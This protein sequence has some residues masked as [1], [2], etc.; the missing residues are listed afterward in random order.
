LMTSGLFLCAGTLVPWPNLVSHE[1]APGR[2]PI[3]RLRG[4]CQPVS[5]YIANR[6]WRQWMPYPGFGS[7]PTF[8]GSR[9]A[10]RAFRPGFFR[11][12]SRKFSARLAKFRRDTRSRAYPSGPGCKVRAS[13]KGKGRVQPRQRLGALEGGRD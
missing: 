8:G 2:K 9:G 10:G 5:Q 3:L 7:D 6:H 11:S 13:L 4:D 1:V 12:T